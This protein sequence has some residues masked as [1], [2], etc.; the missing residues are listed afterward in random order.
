MSKDGL[1]LDIIGP[2]RGGKSDFAA[3]VSLYDR[4]G[5]TVYFAFDHNYKSAVK[6]HISLGAKITVEEFF[7]SLPFP[8]PTS[9][10]EKDFEKKVNAVAQAVR[11]VYNRFKETLWK[12]LKIKGPIVLDQMTTLHYVCRL[13]LYGY[14]HKIPRHLYAKRTNEMS[15]ILN[16]IRYSGKNVAM[17]H[18]WKEI[19]D[20][21]DT[22]TGTFMRDGA[23][24][25]VAYEVSAT[26]EAERPA[27]TGVFQVRIK[28]STYN[29]DLVGRRFSGSKRTFARV[30][31]RLLE[32]PK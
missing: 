27:T 24:A 7:Y 3:S 5:P 31:Q 4:A 26:L 29:P 12:V 18:R 17:I 23:F 22:P 1:V 6:R 28:D 15:T 8:P 2:E 9:P 20:K 13:A 25:P 30:A 16:E 32:E 11:P 10:K 19:W 21:N 14:V